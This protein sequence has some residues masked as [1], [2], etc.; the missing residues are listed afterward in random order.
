[1]EIR[2]IEENKYVL[3]GY[4]NAVLRESREL[5]SPIGK[6]KEIVEPNVFRN[7][8]SKADDIK[9]LFNHNES[10]ELGSIS[11]G[12]LELYEDAVGLFCRA[13]ITDEEVIDLAEK[14]ELTG[15]SF[16]FCCN[17]DNWIKNGEKQLRYLEDIDL[18]EVSIL[19]VTPAYEST[20][21]VY[22]ERSN[23]VYERRFVPTT[24]ELPVVA[25][26]VKEE[27]DTIIV[28]GEQEEPKDEVMTEDGELEEFT[29]KDKEEEKAK[30]KFYF[31]V[32]NEALRLI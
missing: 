13:T 8:I 10:R 11:N 31:E 17:K 14:R 16:G 4:V 6:F 9:I 20:S 1:M 30:L 12:N 22:E 26:M 27:G 23:N 24:E 3:Q 19:S 7:A 18:M 21:I 32:I 29:A 25:P 5:N 15:W 2:K 28:T